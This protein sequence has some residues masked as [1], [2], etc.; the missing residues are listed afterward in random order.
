MRE[1]IAIDAASSRAETTRLPIDSLAREF[2]AAVSVACRL[3]WA[4]LAA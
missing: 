1:P 2:E 4:T 3:R